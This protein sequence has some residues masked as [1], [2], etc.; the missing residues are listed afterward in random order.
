MAGAGDAGIDCAAEVAGA[1]EDVGAGA[2]LD[3]NGLAGDGGLVDEGVAG[4]DGGIGRDGFAGKD[5]DFIAGPE[6]GGFDFAVGFA[7]FAAGWE[8]DEIF[9][10]SAKISRSAVLPA[11][12]DARELAELR[13]G[14]LHADSSALLQH[15]P[16]EQDD[17][18]DGSGEVFLGG[19]AG[20]ECEDHV[21]VHVELGGCKA[22]GADGIDEAGDDGDGDDEGGEQG[23][24][25][26]DDFLLGT[27]PAAEDG[28]E[29]E[30]GG[31]EE[32]AEAAAR[33]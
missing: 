4:E 24:G 13:E 8:A 19:E 22:G 16:E 31:G 10:G 30:G 18:D 2:D 32:Q 28:G 20:C 12:A 23:E 17:G 27:Q 15:L 25:L 9:A 7:G 14:H 29:H 1:R 3:G 21:L 11:S 5:A 26:A 6:I 33:F